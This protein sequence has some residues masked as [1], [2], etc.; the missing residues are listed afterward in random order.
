MKF[1]W[2]IIIALL[3]FS[4]QDTF[5]GKDI[6]ST[7]TENFEYLWKTLD[8]KYSFFEYKKVD[9]NAMHSKYSKMIYNSMSNNSLFNVMLE[10]LSELKDSH[11]NLS[12]PF[13]ISRY[14][15]QFISSPAN[16]DDKLIKK[17]I[18]NNYFSTGPFIYQIINMGQ[19][20]YLRYESFEDKITSEDIDFV[21]DKLKSTKGIIIDLR[22]NGGGVIANIFTLA[23]RFADKSR[24]IYT[25]YIKN[26]PGHEDF[27]GPNIVTLSPSSNNFKGQ[28]CIL[29]NR[30]SYSATSFFVLAMRNFPN[31]KIVGDTTGG[32]LGAP[33]GA[34]L[35]NGWG[36][37]FSCSRTLSP[38][39][40]NF[41]NGIPPSITVNMT[42]DDQKK[43]KDTII[44]TAMNI[45]LS[46]Q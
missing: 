44:E 29:T 36:I 27:D 13:K 16:Y 42:T 43:G 14:E 12:S 24:H 9:W 23:S 5:L 30:N 21:L 1:Y 22:S 19:I 10:M 6:N 41:E 2:L 35:P 7:P 8:E 32:G 33:T 25:S 26:G 31:V 40:E 18:G 39:G 34:E 46:G 3:L 4:C 15:I 38:E 20:G 45:I 28:V 11:V 37:R 17:Y